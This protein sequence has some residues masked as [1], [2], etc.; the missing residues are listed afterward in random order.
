V[1]LEDF[2]AW[3]ERSG[4]SPHTR[5]AYRRLMSD[6]VAFLQESDR[7]VPAVLADEHERTFAARDWRQHLRHVRR[8]APASVNQ[9]L[10][11]LHTYC[12]FAGFSVPNVKREDLPQLA[13]RALEESEQKRLLRAI[14]RTKSARDRAIAYTLF[15]TGLRIAE[16][17]GLD[18]ADVV[19]SERRGK[20]IVRKG[21][22][23]RQ[24]EAPLHPV[25]REALRMWLRERRERWG[26]PEN[27]GVG[28]PCFLSYQGKRLSTRSM[29]KLMDRLG[30]E[31]A[32][33]GLSAHV[34]RHTFTTNLIRAGQDLV[35]VAELTGH[36]RLETIRR[37]SLPTEEDKERALATLPTDR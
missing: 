19:V 11:A 8:L 20:L 23:D 25:A 17:A 37:Y 9:A 4:T 28:V 10:A 6:F 32:I 36:A 35:L 13:P 22:G 15:Y 2:A 24:R 16:V 12:Q 33:E 30:E 31:A 34:L 3:L 14:E 7:D 29:D 26:E 18:L 1:N 27:G 5:R 21:K